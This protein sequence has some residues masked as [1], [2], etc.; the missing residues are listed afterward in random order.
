[1]RRYRDNHG[2]EYTENGIRRIMNNNEFISSNYSILKNSTHDLNSLSDKES[3]Q[4]M[5]N[6]A[7]KNGWRKI[8]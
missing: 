7:N 8:E 5:D 3:V 2:T 1:M 4:I 6:I